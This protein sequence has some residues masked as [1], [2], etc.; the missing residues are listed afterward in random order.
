MGTVSIS[1]SNKLSLLQTTTKC[2]SDRKSKLQSSTQGTTRRQTLSTGPGEG[3]VTGWLVQEPSPSQ[4]LGQFLWI[5]PT[6]KG[7]RRRTTARMGRTTVWRSSTGRKP[8]RRRFPLRELSLKNLWTTGLEG[9]RVTLCLAG[10][11]FSHVT[12]NVILF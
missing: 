7:T 3:R 6:N 12:Q 1:L 11:L 2:L 10:E 4:E 8:S 5:L 9:R